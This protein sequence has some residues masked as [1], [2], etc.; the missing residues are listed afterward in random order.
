[1]AAGSAAEI[2][3][4]HAGDAREFSCRKWPAK[5]AAARFDSPECRSGQRVTD[6]DAKAELRFA[7]LFSQVST[8]RA[9]GRSHVR[10]RPRRSTWRAEVIDSS[11]AQDAGAD[12]AVHREAGAARAA[13]ENLRP[14]AESM[15]H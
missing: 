11:A 15:S 12:R 14:V 13:P 5:S 2:V 9:P 3:Q 6:C 10:V 7:H 8:R 4:R 1:M